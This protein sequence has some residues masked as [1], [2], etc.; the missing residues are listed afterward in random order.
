MMSLFIKTMLLVRHDRNDNSNYHSKI[1]V[2]WLSIKMNSVNILKTYICK[3]LPKMLISAQNINIYDRKNQYWY[4]TQYFGPV[5]INYE[6]SM[7]RYK[8][9]W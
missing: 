4:P 3:H 2:L 8:G 6:I 7:D 5:A 9:Y 1:L